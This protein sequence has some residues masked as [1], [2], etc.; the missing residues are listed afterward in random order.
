MAVGFKFKYGPPNA[1][2]TPTR[3]GTSARQQD[4]SVGSSEAYSGLRTQWSFSSDPMESDH[5]SLCTTLYIDCSPHKEIC[6]FSC[7]TFREA[8]FNLPILDFATRSKEF[9]AQDLANIS[10]Q[11][12]LSKSRPSPS[13]PSLLILL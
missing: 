9:C 11:R 8:L 6:F 2:D 4:T 12:T 3:L 5:V 7:D 1:D 13:R 10:D